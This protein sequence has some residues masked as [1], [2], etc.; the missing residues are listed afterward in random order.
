MNVDWLPCW[1]GCTHRRNHDGPCTTQPIAFLDPHATYARTPD[2]QDVVIPVQPDRDTPSTFHV[3]KERLSPDKKPDTPP[4]EFSMYTPDPTLPVIPVIQWI[5][6][7]RRLPADQHYVLLTG[8][9]GMT[10]TSHFV[11]VGQ[12]SMAYRPPINGKIR[13]LGVTNTDLSDYGFEP[14]HWAPLPNLPD[15]A[16]KPDPAVEAERKLLA[17]LLRKHPDMALQGA[18]SLDESVEAAVA[19]AGAF[20][21]TNEQVR[22]LR[23]HTGASVTH[24]RQALAR[25]DND[26]DRAVEDIRRQ[27]QCSVTRDPTPVGT[28][29]VQERA[30]IVSWLQQNAP[31]DRMS[32]CQAVFDA[33]A[34]VITQG[35]HWDGEPGEPVDP[36]PE[37]R[38]YTVERRRVTAWLRRAIGP[39]ATMLSCCAHTW[40]TL[41]NVVESGS[42]WSTRSLSNEEDPWRP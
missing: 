11:V 8:P 33:A 16:K 20:L 18:G 1:P 24:C 19:R 38:H 42:H 34:S 41:A 15:L 32:C 40:S 4:A 14:T 25:V 37:R 36:T 35:E 26:F 3:G 10:S 13:W 21:R 22:T 23:A 9:S 7:D 2:A 28:T 31:A 5:P 39:G 30:R 17:E 12:R 27:G 6:L 29:R